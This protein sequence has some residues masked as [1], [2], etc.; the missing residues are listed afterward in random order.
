[1]YAELI[2]RAQSFALLDRQNKYTGIPAN[3]IAIPI[4]VFCG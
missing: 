3:M 4:N 1:M 2:S